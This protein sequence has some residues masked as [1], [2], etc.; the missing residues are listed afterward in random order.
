MCG[1]Q[2]SII[3]AMGDY[4]HVLVFLEVKQEL[5]FAILYLLLRNFVDKT[6]FSIILG[7]VRV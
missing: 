6:S 5:F 1:T 2:T 7:L 3:V 4:Y